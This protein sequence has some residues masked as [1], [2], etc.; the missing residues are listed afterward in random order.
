MLLNHLKSFVP[1]LK[2][3]SYNSGGV[4]HL[5]GHF[6]DII[7]D[8][9][10]RLSN[11]QS[12]RIKS[13]HTDFQSFIHSFIQSQP[14]FCPSPKIIKNIIFIRSQN[15]LFWQN[16]GTMLGSEN[17]KRKQSLSFKIFYFSKCPLVSHG[18]PFSQFVCYLQFTKS[19]QFSSYL[20]YT[21]YFS[22]RFSRTPIQFCISTCMGYCK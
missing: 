15:L 11:N 4:I 20:P 8:L 14:L 5:P 7:L 3:L 10:T 21:F 12:I 16:S 22:Q 6:S 18:F 13:V 17:A 1:V 9:S 19:C 2:S